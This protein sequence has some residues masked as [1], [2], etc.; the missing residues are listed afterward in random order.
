MVR[1]QQVFDL[2]SHIDDPTLNLSRWPALPYDLV[3]PISHQHRS[4]RNRGF[5][6]HADGSSS[7]CVDAGCDSRRRIA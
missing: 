4:P 7:R 5:S 1:E 2:V 6:R 3:K